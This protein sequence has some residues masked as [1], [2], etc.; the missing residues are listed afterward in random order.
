MF[1]LVLLS[2]HPS[3]SGR[4]DSVLQARPEVPEGWGDPRGAPCA[5]GMGAC[6]SMF[7]RCWQTGTGTEPAFLGQALTPE[8]R[9]GGPRVQFLPVPFPPG[10]QSPARSGSGVWVTVLCLSERAAATRCGPGPPASAGCGAS[11]WRDG[12]GLVRSQRRQG[13]CSPGWAGPRAPR[14]N[15]GAGRRPRL[16]GISPAGA[17]GCERGAYTAD[18]WELT[19]P[20]S[21][22]GNESSERKPRCQQGLLLRRLQG[23]SVPPFARLGPAL[24]SWPLPHPQSTRSLCRGPVSLSLVTLSS[25]TPTLCGPSCRDPVRARALPVTRVPPPSPKS[26]RMTPAESRVPCEVTVHRFRGQGRGSRAGG[27]GSTCKLATPSQGRPES[28]LMTAP[29]TS[30]SPPS[31]A[32]SLTSLRSHHRNRR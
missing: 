15:E 6:A 28:Q 19:T 9:R 17:T 22:I 23:A 7:A 3:L 24:R 5:L 18:T 27:I 12:P 16:P 2:S 10:G 1:V 20:R 8:T 4:A 21:R 14:G 11:A 13:G 32:R 26:E 25:L 29:L 30:T 31:L